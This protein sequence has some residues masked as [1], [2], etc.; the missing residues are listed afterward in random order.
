MQRS[1]LGIIVLVGCEVPAQGGDTL[2]GTGAATMGLTS[3]GD[4]GTTRVL[5]TGEVTQGTGS[6]GQIADASTTAGDCQATGCVIDACEPG[7]I[8]CVDP[9]RFET[10]NETG[11]GWGKP[12]ACGEKQGCYFNECVDLCTIAAESATS[13]GCSFLATTMLNGASLLPPDGLVV[14]NASTDDVASVDLHAVHLGRTYPL[15]SVELNPGTGH[16]FLM[17]ALAEPLP[18]QESSVA[19]RVVY[20][21]VSDAP[22]VAYLH[23]TLEADWSNDATLLLPDS[24]LGDRYVIASNTLSN[25]SVRLGY[26]DVIALED[27]TTVEWTP[28]GPTAAATGVP[29]ASASQTVEATLNQFEHL[30]V[31]SA[32]GSDISGTIVE[33]DAPIWVVGAHE[34]ATPFAWEPCDLVMEQMLPITQWGDQYV[35]PTAPEAPDGTPTGWRIFGGADVTVALD[36]PLTGTSY[37]L[38]LGEY[39][40]VLVD[41][42]V[43][44]TADGPFLPVQFI[45]NFYIN[46]FYDVDASMLQAVPVEQFLSRYVFSTAVNYPFHYV[47]VIRHSGGSDVNVNGAPVTGFVSA[48]SNYEIADY[49]LIEGT[50]LVESKD[51]FGIL[52]YGYGQFASYAFAGG[53]GLAAINPAG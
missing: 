16:T 4:T 2:G 10:C 9:K 49:P 6:S 45:P 38:G 40:D 36:P 31:V 47:Q 12:T 18:T 24:T 21:V 33:A 28:T 32:D 13:E 27:A 39:V 11:V 22:V 7:A 23:S 37:S 19:T 42:D 25:L 30:R 8:Q 44:M 5:S 20:R 43:T 53:L 15:D 26:F 52:V 14:A 3:V 41:G 50:H 1:W 29:A 35:T 51:A 34:C 17:D 46:Q 48:G